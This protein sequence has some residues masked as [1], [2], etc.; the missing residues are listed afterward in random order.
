[1][2]KNDFLAAVEEELRL[3]GIPFERSALVEYIASMWPWI[4]GDPDVYRWA[5]EFLEAYS[6]VDTPSP[7]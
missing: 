4:D 3:R 5:R 1:M 2:S 7:G 6:P